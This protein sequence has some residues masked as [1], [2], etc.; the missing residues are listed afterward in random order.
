VVQKV[1]ADD[2][3]R[4]GPGGRRIRQH[5]AP[6]ATRAVCSPPKQIPT[7]PAFPRVGF[8]HLRAVW[9]F[10]LDTRSSPAYAPPAS[11]A[12]GLPE[13]DE[14]LAFGAPP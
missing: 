11:L 1:K 10:L 13:C 3:P 5:A 12:H 2:A 9:A 7:E 14:C 8:D 4:R 6:P